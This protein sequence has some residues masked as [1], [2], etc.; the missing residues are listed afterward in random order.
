MVAGLPLR[1]LMLPAVVIALLVLGGI[2]VLTFLVQVPEE[3]DR[4][5]WADMQHHFDPAAVNTVELTQAGLRSTLTGPEAQTFAQALL[6]GTFSE[7][8]AQHFG[9]TPEI[10][11]GF[12]FPGEEAFRS[13]QWPDGRFE[14]LWSG[15]Q[16]LVSSPRLAGLLEQKGFV[17]VER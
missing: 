8:N 17:Y 15:R 5:S 4:A 2:F 7:G 13:N 16:F 11:V 1:R 12:V 6:A 9:P 14:V 3:I 10:G